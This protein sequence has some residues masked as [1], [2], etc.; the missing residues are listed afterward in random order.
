MG[1]V[2]VCISHTV[3]A[4]IASTMH[5]QPHTVYAHIRIG[6]HHVII[7]STEQLNQR[8]YYANLRELVEEMFK[9]NDNNRV[10][11]LVFSKGGPV[12]HY[13]LT[14]IV[15]QEWKDTYIDSYI[16]LAA[17]FS[18]ISIALPTLLTV[19]PTSFFLFFEIQ[20]SSQKL[21]SLKH[22]WP[23]YYFM[24]PHASVWNDTVLVLTPTKNYTAND[25][26]QLFADAGFPQGYTQ[27]RENSVIGTAAPNVSTYCFY[28][29][30]IPTPLTYVYGDDFLDAQP[31]FING[32]GDGTVNKE[33][34]EACLPWANSGYPFNRTVFQGV[35]HFSILTDKAALQA[36]GSIVRAPMDP[37]DGKWIP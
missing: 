23:T 7:T 15:T 22:S 11:L 26:Q 16:A 36:I 29:L 20:A 33:S 8:D 37:I 5:K 9:Q 2:F 4:E 17:V 21:H 24:L 10:T 25:Y 30:G 27:F 31:T 35:D 6:F 13:F 32:E 14:R 12:S 3:H 19:S 18:G 34:L 28:G 1:P